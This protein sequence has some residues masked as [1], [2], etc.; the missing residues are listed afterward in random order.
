[1]PPPPS[2]QHFFKN[3]RSL[4]SHS[5]G[6]QNAE[7]KVPG[8]PETSCL[9]ESCLISMCSLFFPLC[10]SLGSPHRARFLQLLRPPVTM[11]SH[12]ILILNNYPLKYPVSKFSLILR[13]WGAQHSPRSDQLICAETSVV[14]Q[15]LSALLASALGLSAGSIAFSF[16]YSSHTDWSAFVCDSTLVSS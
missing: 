3:N 10:V 2:L 1:M 8:G 14:L 15:G 9:V 12:N 16:S 5:S 4:F 13:S 7:I 6:G 11:D